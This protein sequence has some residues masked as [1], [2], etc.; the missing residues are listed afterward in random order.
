MCENIA[1][2]VRDLVHKID[3]RKVSC[4]SSF[5]PVEAAWYEPSLFD[6][7]LVLRKP[8]NGPALSQCRFLMVRLNLSCC[9]R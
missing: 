9:K 4:L 7:R 2:F 8:N 5:V 3:K 1:L 6:G